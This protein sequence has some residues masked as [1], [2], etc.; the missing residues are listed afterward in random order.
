VHVTPAG[1]VVLRGSL[2]ERL[3]MTVDVSSLVQIVPIVRAELCVSE[4]GWE[5]ARTHAAEI[6]THWRRRRAAQPKLF[7]GEVLMLHTWSLADGCFRG[8]CLTTDFKNLL[9]WREN[10]APDGAVLDFF[11][12]P[13][14]HSREGWLI[15]V[16]MGPDHSIAG[17]IYFPC[18]TLHPSDVVGQTIDLDGG[19][20]R[21]L[22]E[23]TGLAFSPADLAA[24][25]LIFDRHRLAFIRPI[26]SAR[27]AAEIVRDIETHL[28]RTPEPELSEIVVVK[29]RDDIDAASMP[30]YVIAYIEAAFA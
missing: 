7:N 17:K 10:G 21:E 5:F 25:L 1:A 11:G 14:L 3:R 23:E 20:L 26:R 16:R 8:E 6:D 18:G 28:A 15:V 29:G 30:P 22:N 13:A 27:A 12:A 2:R 24:P 9:Y 4:P 19:I